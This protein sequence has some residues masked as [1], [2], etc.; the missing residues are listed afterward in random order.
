MQLK[1]A[2]NGFI[3]GIFEIGLMLTQGEP[4]P[5]TVDWSSLSPLQRQQVLNA[6]RLGQVTCDTD[7]RTLMERELGGVIA[8]DSKRKKIEEISLA[9]L[10]E[11]IGKDEL[12]TTAEEFLAM[13]SQ[14]LRPHVTR[15]QNLRLVN[16]MIQLEA[17]GKKRKTVL[18]WL[19][20]KKKNLEEQIIASCQIEVP[21]KINPDPI[22]PLVNRYLKNIEHTVEEKVTVQLPI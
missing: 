17:G 12:E 6:I 7:V 14:S 5:K 10:P 11:R 4:G 20:D 2:E 16:K 8:A 21:G 13:G 9:S 15:M 3:W 18:S 19:H 1:L 22:D